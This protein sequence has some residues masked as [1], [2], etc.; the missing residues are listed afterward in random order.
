MLNFLK[1][2]IDIKLKCIC[3]LCNKILKKTRSIKIMK[4]RKE[5]FIGLVSENDLKIALH[6]VDAFKVLYE[7]NKYQD[8]IV[9]PAL[10]LIRQFLELGLKYNIRKLSSIS[11]SSNLINDLSKTHDLCKIYGSFLDH[12]KN[13]KKNLGISG[14]KD[15]NLLK[16]LDSLVNL[17]IPFDNDSM[18]YR[19]SEDQNGNKL[20]DINSTHN[21][22]NVYKL[23]ETTSCFISSTEDV[24]GLTS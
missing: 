10:F 4:S 16:D 19:Y 23:L 1:S 24:F 20:I 15:G 14:L 9:I 5:S 11:G 22:E 13:A 8:Q 6:Y 2:I 18:G 17:I 7:S 12:Y 21:L 3:M